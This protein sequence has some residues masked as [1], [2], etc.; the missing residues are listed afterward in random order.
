MASALADVTGR[1][2]E[3]EQF[4]LLSGVFS[5][6]DGDA[7]T[8]SATSSANAVATVSVVADYHT[9]TVAG[10]AEG[11]AT[12]TVTARDADGN[13]VSDA[14][15]VTVAKAEEPQ[16][17]EPETPEK[18]AALIAQMYEWRNDPQVGGRQRAHRPLGP[19]ALGPWRNGGRCVPDADVGIGGLGLRRPGLEPLGAGGGSAAGPGIGIRHLLISHPPA[20]TSRTGAGVANFQLVRGGDDRIACS[21]FS[22]Q[23]SRASLSKPGHVGDTFLIGRGHPTGRPNNTAPT[24]VAACNAYGVAE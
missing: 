19:G 16:E 12:I 24:K 13:R 8:V 11:A 21:R 15:E 17:Q 4:V 23:T 10:V 1:P 2:V 6:A 20:R 7:L 18:Y 14:F 3:S 22:V 5:D 9:L